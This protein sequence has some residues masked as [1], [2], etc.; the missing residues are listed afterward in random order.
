M[1]GV[2]FGEYGCEIT[3]QI[4]TFL[5]SGLNAGVSSYSRAANTSFG[6]VDW[7][8][9]TVSNLANKTKNLPCY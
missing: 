4:Q 2:K 1:K 7:V 6:D 8:W 3:I 9:Y 5:T